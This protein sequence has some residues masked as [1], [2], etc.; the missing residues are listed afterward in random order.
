M[1]KNDPSGRRQRTFL[2]QTRRCKA[3]EG[4]R[5]RVCPLQSSGTVCLK[6]SAATETT[7]PHSRNDGRRVHRAARSGAGDG[8]P[9]SGP[10]LISADQNFHT[11]N[12]PPGPNLSVAWAGSLVLAAGPCARRRHADR[13]RQRAFSSTPLAFHFVRAPPISVEALPE[14]RNP[15]WAVRVFAVPCRRLQPAPPDQEPLQTRVNAGL[16][17]GADYKHSSHCRPNRQLETAPRRQSG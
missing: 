5:D 10:R 12:F 16:S 2:D 3:P 15:A 14:G 1:L 13:R 9:Q 6:L 17:H 11:G 8:G 4:E 7:V